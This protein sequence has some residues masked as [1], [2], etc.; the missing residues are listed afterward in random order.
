MYLT[1]TDLEYLGISCEE[2]TATAAAQVLYARG[3]GG[4]PP[5]SF[6]THILAAW[7]HADVTNA[8]RLSREW[9]AYAAALARLNE[10]DGIER[11]RAIVAGEAAD[12]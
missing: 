6:F 12:A 8:C 4:Y 2:V 10:P 11:L 1:F 5:G 7:C 3:A 9:P